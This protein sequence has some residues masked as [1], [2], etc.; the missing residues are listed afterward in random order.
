VTLLTSAVPRAA[1]AEVRLRV[2]DAGSGVDPST[3]EAAVDGHAR[4][5]S[6]DRAT[7]RATVALG[8]LALG[9]HR[10]TLQVSDYQETRNMEDVPEILP[11]TRAV[12]VA[13]RVTRPR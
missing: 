4:D 2:A 1:G 10:L 3:F 8:L 6:F 9:R 12:N 5:V 7:N 13:F 11:N